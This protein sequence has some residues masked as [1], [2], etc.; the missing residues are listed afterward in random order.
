MAPF[1]KSLVL[2]SLAIMVAV[3][4]AARIMKEEG[5]NWKLFPYIHV[6][7]INCLD[8][9]E[10]LTLHCKSKTEDEG[11]HIRFYG[12]SFEFQFKEDYFFSRTL[13]FCSFSWPSDTKLHYTDI[14]IQT[15]DG[16]CGGDHY[17]CVWN[18]F[19][20]GPCK[21]DNPDDPAKSTFT[22]YDW[23]KSPTLTDALG[24]SASN[25]STPSISYH[26]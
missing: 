22:C 16:D 26:H 18:I 21:M 3:V 4:G 11:V 6:K 24:V 17:T 23:H 20:K 19:E 9:A 10:D 13:F 1:T 25:T 12:E 5:D 15:R 14:Y 8:S 2:L 7:I